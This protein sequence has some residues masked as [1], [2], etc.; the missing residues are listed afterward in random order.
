MQESPLEAAAPHPQRRLDVVATTPPTPSSVV[1]RGGQRYTAAASR[2]SN[3][4]SFPVA[5]ALAMAS[6]PCPVSE[7]D[8]IGLPWS[9]RSRRRRGRPW[10]GASGAARRR[11]RG[12][13]AAELPVGLDVHLRVPVSPCR[14]GQP[15][16]AA[17]DEGRRFARFSGF[18][19]V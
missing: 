14:R 10:R 7:E 13:V 18:N 3:Q 2:W 19:P 16:L 12:V 1:A 5:E 4:R 6:C 15:W 9:P 17:R 8:D 11:H